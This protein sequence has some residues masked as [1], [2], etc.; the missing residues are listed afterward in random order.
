M[1]Q[2]IAILRAMLL[3]SSQQ[4]ALLVLVCRLKEEEPT[5]VLSPLEVA[6]KLDL[7]S[8]SHPWQVCIKTDTSIKK[9][10]ISQPTAGLRDGCSFYM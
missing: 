7:C 9:Y 10:I 5:T 2:D 3:S 4:S 8:L 6:D 1:E